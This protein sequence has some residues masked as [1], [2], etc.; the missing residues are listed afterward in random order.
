MRSKDLPTVVEASVLSSFD[1]LAAMIEKIRVV[2]VDEKIKEKELRETCQSQKGRAESHLERVEHGQQAVESD[3]ERLN[4]TLQETL[5]RISALVSE[6]QELEAGLV[7]ETSERSQALE[8][9]A[10]STEEQLALQRKLHGAIEELRRVYSSSSRPA[11]QQ[12]RV[13]VMT[14]TTTTFPGFSGPLWSSSGS[15]SSRRGGLGV[16]AI[17]EILIEDSEALVESMQQAQSKGRDAGSANAASTRKALESKDAELVV[18]QSKSAADEA[19]REQV[20]RERTRGEEEVQEIQR[21][22]A[23]VA[24]K[25]EHALSSTFEQSQAS[26]QRQ[27]EN[28]QSAKAIMMQQAR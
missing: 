26:R 13:A 9:L 5:N 20:A 15:D 25:C 28:L 22:L 17:L 16:I 19:E 24:E 2:L 4:G 21:L 12:E 7:T 6:A 8:G 11:L 14:A 27:I 1:A 3:L 18:L 23:I 10:K